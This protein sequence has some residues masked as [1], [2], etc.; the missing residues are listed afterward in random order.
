M[1]KCLKYYIIQEK[2]I[3]VEIIKGSCTLN[4]YISFKEKL[5]EDKDFNPDYSYIIDIREIDLVFSSELR[6]RMK[7]YLEFEKSKDFLSNK[8]KI[9]VITNTPDQV[10]YSTINKIF[11]DRSIIYS[12]FSTK[13]AALSWLGLDSSELNMIK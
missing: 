4:E 12:I 5:I 2:R 7:E 9:A 6:T 10:V 1:D 8:K 11:D 3:I 13:N